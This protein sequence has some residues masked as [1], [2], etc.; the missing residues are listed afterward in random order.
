MPERKVNRENRERRRE[1]RRNKSRNTK[2]RREEVGTPQ[3][4]RHSQRD[5]SLWR[6]R[7]KEQQR[8]TAMS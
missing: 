6:V 1:S 7:R 2:V 4:S 3:W 8:E 5:C